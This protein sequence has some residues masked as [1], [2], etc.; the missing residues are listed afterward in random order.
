MKALLVAPLALL[1]G[2]CATYGVGYS[3]PAYYGQP[4]YGYGYSQPAYA[5]PSFSAGYY[6]YDDRGQ[7]HRHPDGR[8][9]RDRDGDGI[10]NRRDRDRDGDGVRN[11]DDRY[12]NNP[13]RH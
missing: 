6:Y 8:A 11:R 1:L 13:R 12:P 2:G 3:D 9:Y 4:G 7:R 5:Y 10:A